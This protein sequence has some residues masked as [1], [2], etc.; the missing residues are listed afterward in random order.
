MRAPIVLLSL[1][2][3]SCG[4]SGSS[5][6]DDGGSGDGGVV[7]TTD[8]SKCELY[9]TCLNLAAQSA[10]PAAL[11]LY[12]DSSAC[13]QNSTTSANCA[14]ACV[15]AYDMIDTQCN[16]TSPTSCALCNSASL[17]NTSVYGTDYTA[18]ASA[19]SC[20]T[21]DA[22][23][24]V[25]IYSNADGT[26]NVRFD[27]DRMNEG[28]NEGLGDIDI[29]SAPITCDGVANLTWSS[30]GTACASEMLTGTGALTVDGSGMVSLTFSVN[31][32]CSSGTIDPNPCTGT[33]T[34]SPTS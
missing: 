4:G 12:G 33:F 9:L 10:Y 30:T 34:L 22:S 31:T 27:A 26:I 19:G 29:E 14:S 21:V 17:K 28:E 5:S 23:S 25:S 24:N 6:K 20:L 11:A 8:K 13:W 7:A 3:M 2:A 1:L 18:T 16:C 32:T 15:T